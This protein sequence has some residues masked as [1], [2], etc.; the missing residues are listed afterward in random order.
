MAPVG[1]ALR[2]MLAAAGLASGGGPGP[3]ATDDF[4]DDDDTQLEDHD[5]TWQVITGDLHIR[6]NGL[7]GDSTGLSLA[8]WNA[9]FANNQ[10]AQ[11]TYPYLNLNQKTGIA[12][13]VTIGPTVNFYGFWSPWNYLFKYVDG[14]YTEL[15]NGD[16]TNL[17][18][19]GQTVRLEANGTVIRVLFDDIEV[20]SAVDSDLSSG[21]AGVCSNGPYNFLTRIDNWEGGDL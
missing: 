17:Q 15:D 18:A 5:L 13:R 9:T 2:A 6:S 4:T 16:T 1:V 7:T 3:V 12:V 19:G 10:Y 8:G 20:L 14:V 21:V 11:C